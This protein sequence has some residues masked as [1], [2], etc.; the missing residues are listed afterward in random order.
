M[1]ETPVVK[2]NLSEQVILKIKNY[3][4]DHGL[5][6]GDRLPTEQE[7]TQQFGVSR[8]CI[9]EATRS[10]AFLGVINGAPR[11]GLTVARMNMRQ[12][13]EF[14][15]F[16]FALCDYSPEQLLQTR[17]VIEYGSLPFAMRAVMRDDGLYHRLLDLSEKLAAEKDPQDY[18][19]D[20]REFHRLLVAAGGIEPLIA[21]NDLLHVFF[22]KFRQTVVQSYHALQ[23]SGESNNHR[24]IVSALRRGKLKNVQDILWRH[25][26]IYR[27]MASDQQD[28]AE[29]QENSLEK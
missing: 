9:R 13:G 2:I 21:F 26:E 16:H 4:I 29:L 19:R 18:I 3:I 14:M 27:E 15:G 1:A 23:A 10:L 22:E 5:K 11:R 24:G 28:Q 6:P 20:D 12:L 7:M 25:L 8:G 17:M